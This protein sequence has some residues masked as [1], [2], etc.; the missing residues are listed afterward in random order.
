MFRETPTPL[1]LGLP[2]RAIVEIFLQDLYSVMGL[3]KGS[4]T[5]MDVEVLDSRIGFAGTCDFFMYCCW[6]MRWKGCTW[7]ALLL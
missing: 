7:L 1:P 5:S 3:K 2:Y 4:F 6:D